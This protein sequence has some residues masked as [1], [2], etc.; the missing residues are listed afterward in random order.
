[1]KDAGLGCAGVAWPLTLF[2]HHLPRAGF[3]EPNHGRAHEYKA[4]VAIK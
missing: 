3:Y 1:M 4:L 2:G